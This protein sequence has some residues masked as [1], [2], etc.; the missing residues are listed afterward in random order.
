MQHYFAS[1]CDGKA[2][3]SKEDEHHLLHVKRG[4]IGEEIEISD[5]SGN[6]YSGIIS[7]LSPLEI[8]LVKL[9]EEERELPVELTLGFRLLKGDHNDLIVLKGSEL[10]VHRFVPILNDRSI[11]KPKE[12]SDNR[13]TRLQKIAIE[14]AKQCRRSFIPEVTPYASFS[15]L[16]SYD[17]D[18]KIIAYEGEKGSSSSLISACERMK[19]GDKVLALI[20]PEGG[21]SPEE[22]R[23]AKENGFLFVSLGKRIL[24]AETAALYLASIIAAMTE[25]DE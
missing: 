12:K 11:V 25:K 23:L 10:G 5:T 2:F 7:S 16:L 22:V 14:G 19:K 9:A 20:G 18:I 17:A 8:T 21:F 1:I 15:E 4:R 13:I 24:R 3:L 6:T